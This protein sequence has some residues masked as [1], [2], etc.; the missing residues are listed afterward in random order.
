MLN[1]WLKS[2]ALKHHF[3]PLEL[4]RAKVDT[5]RGLGV[6]VGLAEGFGLGPSA[7]GV[8]RLSNAVRDEYGVVVLLVALEHLEL[9]ETG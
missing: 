5:F 9:L 1:D 6:G 4:W 2:E 7:E 3:I 8:F